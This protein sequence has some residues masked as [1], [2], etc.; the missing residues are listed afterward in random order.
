MSLQ[1]FLSSYFKKTLT[2][3]LSLCEAEVSPGSRTSPSHTSTHTPPRE[4]R[5]H[6]HKHA[7]THSRRPVH[8][9][10][11]GGRAGAR[12]HLRLAL[13]LGELAA[14][15]DSAARNSDRRA[16][17]PHCGIFF[18]FKDISL[19]FPLFCS[20]SNGF[21]PEWLAE[22]SRQPSRG[23]P[24]WLAILHLAYKSLLSAVQRSARLVPSAGGRG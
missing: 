12:S 6:T 23:S 1:D 20:F 11:A 15:H 8:L 5:V 9:P 4:P 10:G 13:R 22:P 17:H 7:R 16:E 18:F 21:L 19:P 24:G 14:L 2:G 3:S